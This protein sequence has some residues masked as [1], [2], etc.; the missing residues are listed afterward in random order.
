MVSKRIKGVV[1]SLVAAFSLA[2][3]APA[4]AGDA[5][6]VYSGRS[7]KFVKPVFEAFTERTG[8]E[9]VIH[10][11]KSTALLN[12]LRVE[13]RRTQADLFVSN[14][15]GNLQ[16]GADLGLFDPLPAALVEVIPANLRATDNSWIGLSARARVLVV[17]KA[18]QD[19]L[20]WVD[21]VFDL[22]DPRLEGRL[23]IT[24]SANESYIA[25][26]TVYM[27]AAGKEKVKAWLEGMKRNVDGEVF[28]KHSKIVAAV[29]RGDKDV[30]LVNHYYIFRHLDKHPDAPI[31]IV[32]PDQ[33]GMGVA[34]NV[35]GIAI[36]KYSD[37]KAE[38]RK[39]VEF[40]ISEEG[41]RIFA[42]VN[43]EYPTRPGVPAA[44]QVPA[45]GSYKVADVPMWKLGRERDATID[46]IESVGMP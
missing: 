37:H 22:A 16:I 1:A 15:A 20:K 29:A 9:V 27:E 10:S 34:W 40:L 4:L 35:A 46:L 8:I 31:D 24:H 2:A 45:A 25:G 38:A 36:S 33:E 17:N 18:K 32:L 7:D 6:V 30:G 26:V 41:Q 23:A 14:D 12:K 43:R 42:E 19:S 28:N 11:G 13:G 5:L 21:S 44:P 39:L 3:V